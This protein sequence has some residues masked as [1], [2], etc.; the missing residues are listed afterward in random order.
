LK[1]AIDSVAG[2]FVMT[3]YFYKKK[4]NSGQ[5]F[6]IPQILRVDDAYF[7]GIYHGGKDFSY[8]YKI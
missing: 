2:L 3:L 5:L 6:P 7:E 8:G 1:N 4:A